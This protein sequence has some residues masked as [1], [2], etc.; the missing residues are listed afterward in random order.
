MKTETQESLPSKPKTFV[1]KEGE[2]YAKLPVNQFAKQQVH[3]KII[4]PK[5]FFLI[6]D[7]EVPMNPFSDDRAVELDTFKIR[8]R[9]HKLLGFWVADL[10][11]LPP[12]AKEQYVED[13]LM[14]DLFQGHTS[15]LLEKIHTDLSKANI[16]MSEAHLK[17][18]MDALWHS[19]NAS[20]TIH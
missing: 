10:L 11:G 15:D 19:A 2:F 18:Q 6:F 8:S 4:N 12:K 5:V 9:T 16:L 7:Q 14:L 3:Y 20:L 13:L 17:N 1:P